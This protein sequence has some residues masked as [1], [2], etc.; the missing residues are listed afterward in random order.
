MQFNIPVALQ[1]TMQMQIHPSGQTEWNLRL[2]QINGQNIHY[3]QSVLPLL[4]P[5]NFP[6]H[7]PLMHNMMPSLTM[8]NFMQMPMQLQPMVHHAPMT[9]APTPIIQEVQEG[10]ATDENNTLNPLSP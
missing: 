7:Q 8:P 10:H 2:D 3:A 5:Q 1:G 4:G 6:V 9:P